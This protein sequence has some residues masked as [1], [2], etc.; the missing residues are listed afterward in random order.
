MKL[1]SPQLLAA[2]HV[3]YASGVDDMLW[4]CAAIAIAAAVLAALFLPRQARAPARRTR[5]SNGPPARLSDA[6]GVAG[7]RV[8][9]PV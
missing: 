1:R 6:A 8:A 5:V 4:V 7:A 2:V 9:G 3:A